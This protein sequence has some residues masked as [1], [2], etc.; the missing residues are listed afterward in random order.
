M[1]Y[2][3]TDNII[4]GLVLGFTSGAAIG[5]IVWM[6]WLFET[7]LFTSKTLIGGSILIC[8]FFGGTGGVI[9]GLYVL[10]FEK[11]PGKTAIVKGIVIGI[12][13][14]LIITIF[15]LILSIIYIIAELIVQ[16]V[17]L[18]KEVILTLLIATAS[19]F[20]EKIINMQYFLNILYG[21]LYGVI[22]GKLWESDF[23]KISKDK[24]DEVI[25][26]DL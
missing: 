24:E 10:L 17:A 23:Q 4:R 16:P 26:L 1:R 2:S 19:I 6:Q 18:S 11:L 7:N 20:T 3:Q 22:L 15:A 9:G 12:L 8:L 25:D 13:P 14:F 5:I 21:A